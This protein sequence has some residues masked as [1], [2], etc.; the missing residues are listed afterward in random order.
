M[1]YLEQRRFLDRYS[2]TWAAYSA[3]FLLVAVLAAWGTGPS[4]GALLL[5]AGVVA[6]TLWYQP[7]YLHLHHEAEKRYVWAVRSRWILILS[8]GL[9]AA[10]WNRSS[11]SGLMWT[12]VAVAWLLLVNGLVMLLCRGERV[13]PYRAMP[14][15]YFLTDI[16]V[17]AVLRERAEAMV[18]VAFLLLSAEFVL[19]IDGL[20]RDSKN[21][22]KLFVLFLPVTV[23]ILAA[24][25]QYATK[26]IPWVSVVVVLVGF[27]ETVELRGLAVLQSQRNYEETLAE[28]A[29]FT[30]ASREETAQRLV[31]SAQQLAESWKTASPDENDPAA[32]ARWYSENSL[33]YLFDTAMFH[34]RYKHIVFSLDVL[35]I[36]RGR[37]LDYG[38]GKGALAV[39][40]ARQG[41]AV[42]Y[43]DV[44]GT[45]RQYAEWNAKRNGLDLVFASRKEEILA[46]VAAR[47]PYDT[48]LSLDVLE[49]LPDLA[50]EL[51]FLRSVLAPG[52]KVILTV[53]EGATAAHPMHLTHN[54]STKAFLLARGLRDAK[55]WKQRWLASEILRK[56]HCVI[57]QAPAHGSPLR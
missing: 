20:D 27:Y 29:G 33:P 26:N 31:T 53:P 15:I 52:G 1:V 9:L 14:W 19:L 47:G 41:H 38:A 17:F 23:V 22:S 32:L 16:L 54:V 50:G 18:P 2:R 43:F 49:H 48:I 45:S 36:C 34:L 35:K 37:C 28:I 5:T 12:V 21:P 25:G 57:L 13:L 51:E 24:S 7:K 56:P 4:G 8:L 3:L 46:E 40:L 44:P 30:G 42:T 39:E 11:P 55:T 6:A 10:A